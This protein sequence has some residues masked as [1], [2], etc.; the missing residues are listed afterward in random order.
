MTRSLQ[1]F[2][3]NMSIPWLRLQ[4]LMAREYNSGNLQ[5]SSFKVHLYWIQ[6]QAPYFTNIGEVLLPYL[7]ECFQVVLPMVVIQL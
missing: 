3:S 4:G 5:K 6:K 2:S 7:F 1:V